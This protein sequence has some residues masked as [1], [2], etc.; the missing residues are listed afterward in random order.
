M[1]TQDSFRSTALQFKTRPRTVHYFYLYIIESLRELSARYITWPNAH[2]RAQIKAA[3][4]R[5]TGFPGVVGSIDGTHHDIIGP[6]NQRVMY[7]NRHHS[8]SMNT[9]VRTVI[10][11]GNQGN[12]RGEKCVGNQGHVREITNVSGNSLFFNLIAE[13]KLKFH[14]K[15]VWLIV[16]IAQ[17]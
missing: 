6:R 11:Q 10:N 3:F 13:P 12:V 9:Q 8:Y 2:E 17:N 16:V 5:A 7:V 1:A 15:F 14:F 4:E